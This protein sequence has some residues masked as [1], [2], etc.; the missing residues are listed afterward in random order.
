[1]H[2]FFNLIYFTRMSVSCCRY[3]LP[4]SAVL[5]MALSVPATKLVERAGLTSLPKDTDT[6][7]LN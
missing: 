2:S 3:T 1:M 7:D 5:G 6:W 4:A